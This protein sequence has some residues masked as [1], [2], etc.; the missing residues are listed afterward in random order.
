[1]KAAK[2][3]LI[4]PALFTWASNRPH[5]L[6]SVCTSCENV[7]FPQTD[8]CP[9]CGGTELKSVALKAEGTLWTWT[10][11]AFRPKAPYRGADDDRSF[12]PYF[13]GYVELDGQ[14]RVVSLLRVKD[15]A[16]L[17]IGMP[18]KL[19]LTRLCTEEDGTEVMTYAFEAA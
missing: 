7:T 11:Q 1:M 5:L 2:Q 9:K 3:V 6:G 4:D 19:V 18:M 16:E 13:V 15:E 14:L 8:G 10:T 17:K 12:E